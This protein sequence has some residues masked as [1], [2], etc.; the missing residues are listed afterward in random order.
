MHLPEPADTAAP[1][2]MSTSY[3]LSSMAM[4]PGKGNGPQRLPSHSWWSSGDTIPNAA[5]VVLRSGTVSPES[6][7]KIHRPLRPAH[8]FL[9]L[10]RDWLERELAARDLAVFWTVAGEKLLLGGTDTYTHNH[11]GRL[12]LS[13]Y[14]YMQDSEVRSEQRA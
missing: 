1:A 9:L 7:R 6:T 13:G 8:P 10:D 5:S 3:S 14:A 12:V 4:I 2:C 11:P